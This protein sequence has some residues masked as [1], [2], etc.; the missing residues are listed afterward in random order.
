MRTLKKEK[1]E[2][3]KEANER[4]GGSCAVCWMAIEKR[5]GI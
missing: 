2:K 3:R 4:A 5:R 1:R